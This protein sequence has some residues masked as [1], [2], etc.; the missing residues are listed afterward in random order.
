MKALTF[1]KFVKKRFFIWNCYSWKHEKAC[2]PG[3]TWKRQ[4]LYIPGLLW[5]KSL[6]P[7]KSW[8]RQLF[9][10]SLVKIPPFWN[11]WKKRLFVLKR[12]GEKAPRNGNS[13]K[14]AFFLENSGKRL[15]D[16][17]VLKKTVI[18]GKFSEDS[19]FLKA[20]EKMFFV[21][22]KKLLEVESP[23]KDLYSWKVL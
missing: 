22:E 10:E 11:F 2:R 6:E 9:L 18:L 3:K 20:W 21:L 12:F 1:G 7:E 17:K 14:K 15:L 23:E 4:S 16:L 5:K 19:Y 8:K 13:W